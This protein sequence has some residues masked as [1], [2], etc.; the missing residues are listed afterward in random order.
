[1]TERHFRDSR[2]TAWRNFEASLNASKREFRANAAS[3]P[4]RLRELTGDLNTAK[5][6]SF[7]PALIE[8]L[9]RLVLDGG[10]K[11]NDAR[12]F[13]FKEAACF[14]AFRF[15]NAVRTHWRSFA[16]ACLL[17]YTITIF[18]ALLCAKNKDFTVSI[19]GARAMA[20]IEQMYNPEN[21][22][23]LKP[24]EV[25]TDADMFAFYIFNNAGIAFRT[26][27]GGVLAGVGSLI[28][29][30]LNAVSIGATAGYIIGLGFS[31]TFFSFTSGHSAFELTGIVLSANAGF[32]LGRA[33]F[34]TKRISRAAALGKA[35]KTAF[36][37]IAGASILIFVAA[38]IEAFW[39]SR[40]EIA[41][42]IHYY[43]G[44]LMWILLALYFLF[45]G[46]R[47]NNCAV[48]KGGAF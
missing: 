18:F 39:S 38:V 47:R 37:L 17:F 45:A 25:R 26:F 13:S 41:P 46:R 21:E 20:G 5:A 24:R 32:I 34:T 7:N 44:A 36:P 40:H 12:R 19:L 31:E 1:L 42:I 29:L 4:G 23:F 43:A 8:R 33:F 11:L 2:E 48:S 16:A 15:P 9:N 35:G 22:H 30:V 28:I 27:A 6:N 10:F 14:V 3:F